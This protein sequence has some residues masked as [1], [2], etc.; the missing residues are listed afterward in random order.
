MSEVEKKIWAVICEVYE[1]D[2][3]KPISEKQKELVKE[4][5]KVVKK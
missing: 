2:S 3:D 5:A 4:L 1:I